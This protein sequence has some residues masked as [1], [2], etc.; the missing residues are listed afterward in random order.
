MGWWERLK[1]ENTN[2]RASHIVMGIQWMQVDSKILSNYPHNADKGT[3]VEHMQLTLCY[4]KWV[5]C[6]QTVPIRVSYVPICFPLVKM[7]S[8]F[9]QFYSM[10]N[11]GFVP[12]A[13][14]KKFSIYEQPLN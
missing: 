10:Y 12:N 4:Q 14:F 2:Y 11:C 1:C 7:F 5:L 8:T 6:I 3:Q 13:D 9:V